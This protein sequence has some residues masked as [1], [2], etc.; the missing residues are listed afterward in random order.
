MSEDNGRWDRQD[1]TNSITHQICPQILLSD[2]LIFASPDDLLEH[3]YPI[4][5]S[6]SFIAINYKQGN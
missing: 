5:Q 1:S 2:D 6:A 4:S 3:H